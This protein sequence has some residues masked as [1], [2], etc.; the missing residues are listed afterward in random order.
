VLFIDARALGY[1]VDRAERALTNQEIVRIGDTY[2]AWR[3]SKS[4]VAKK[5]TYENVPG[6]CKSATLAEIKAADY[7]LT[8]GR[9]VGA[10]EVEDDGEPIDEKI[11][12]LRKEL[13]AAF[14]ESAR[15]EK[16]VRE[17]LERIDG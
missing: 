16:V 10:A 7:A 14:D 13:L 15:F 5:L 9:Y 3:G 4:A 12:R 8:P 1:M 17:Q 2:H 6:F 11:A